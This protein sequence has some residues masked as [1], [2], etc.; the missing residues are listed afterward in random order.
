MPV[1]PASREVFGAERGPRAPLRKASASRLT[2]RL[3]ELD[4]LMSR[5]L[6]CEWLKL[7]A[8]PWPVNHYALL[9]LPPGQG[10]TEE[11]EQRVLE[12]MESLRHHQLLYP[13]QVTEGMNLVAQAMICLT[14]PKARYDYDRQLGLITAEYPAPP[15]ESPVIDVPPIEKRRPKPSRPDLPAPNLPAVNVLPAADT[16]AEPVADEILIPELADEEPLRLSADEEDETSGEAAYRLV[17]E[18]KPQA[19]PAEA[20]VDYRTPRRK[21]YANIVRVRRVLRVWE[22]LRAYLDEPEKTF[23]R[24]TDTVAF[25]ACLSELR[26][27]LPTVA[28]LVGGPSQHGNLV[29]VL[30]RQQLIVEMF[31]SL[32]PSQREALA[33]DCQS[34]HYVLLEHYAELRAQARQRTAR[35]FARRVWRPLLRE[36]VARPEW[37]LLGISIVALVVAFYRSVPR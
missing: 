14:D 6:L 33:R 5:E 31:R 16:E 32:L 19:A 13:D 4:A 37:L 26:P 8:A 28:D 22:R 7:P 23:E 21:L 11:I 24:R 35:N 10:T 2:T 18:P 27:L 9:G 17:E 12:R 29:A 34:A 20:P 36:I 25:M 15:P 30:T 1:V 3:H